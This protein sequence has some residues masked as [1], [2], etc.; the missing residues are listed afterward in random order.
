M[1]HLFIAGSAEE[2]A[3]EHGEAEQDPQHREA[4][5]HQQDQE[6]GRTIENKI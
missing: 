5:P 2:K 6:Y 3:G 1:F 4:G